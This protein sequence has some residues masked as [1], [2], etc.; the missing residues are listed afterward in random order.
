MLRQVHVIFPPPVPH[1]VSLRRQEDRRTVSFRRWVHEISPLLDREMTQ[2]MPTHDVEIENPLER[3]TVRQIDGGPDL[4]PDARAGHVGLYRDPK[5]L[6]A[7]EH[8]YKN[9]MP[10]AMHERGAIVLDPVLAVG[11]GAMVAIDRLEG[12]GPRSIRFVRLITYLK[13]IKTL[14][15]AH[16]DL[17]VCTCA[18]DR[19]LDDHGHVRSGLGDAGDHVF[20]TK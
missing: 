14:H 20:G 1:K 13:G 7:V 5:A 9:K 4:V 10:Q 2:D 6:A 15:D 16:P 18:V 17:P 12:A 3:T 8:Y 11:N 19:G